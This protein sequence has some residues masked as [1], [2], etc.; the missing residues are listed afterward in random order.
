MPATPVSPAAPDP[1]ARKSDLANRQAWLLPTDV[2]LFGLRV[3]RAGP[4][5]DAPQRARVDDLSMGTPQDPECPLT[6]IAVK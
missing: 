2:I 3:A 6:F 4:S 5:S 1:Q